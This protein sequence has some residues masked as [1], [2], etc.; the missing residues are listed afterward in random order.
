[1]GS[2][3]ALS[4]KIR[5]QNNNDKNINSKNSSYMDNSSFHSIRKMIIL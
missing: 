2:T 1:M 5:N 3:K 4:T